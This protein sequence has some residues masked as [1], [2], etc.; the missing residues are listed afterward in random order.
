MR[1]IKLKIMTTIASVAIVAGY[2]FV[3]DRE[4]RKGD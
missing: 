3:M 2:Y 4:D 1:K